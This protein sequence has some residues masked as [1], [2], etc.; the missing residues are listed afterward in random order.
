MPTFCV[1]VTTKCSKPNLI[2]SD[3]D[4]MKEIGQRLQQK[5]LQAKL[6]IKE[7]VDMTG[8]PRSTLQNYEAGIR[9]PP[10]ETVKLL[11]G[12]LKTT[13]SYLFTLVDHEGDD[14]SLPFAEIKSLNNPFNN[15]VAFNT[16]I[17]NTKNIPLANLSTLKVEDDLIEPDVMKGSEV[18]IDTSVTEIEKTDIYAIRDDSGRILCLWGRKEVGKNEF[19]VYATKDTHFPALTFSNENENIQIIGR[20]ICVTTW[21]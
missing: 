13:P 16:S 5:R 3:N 12:V 17:L 15:S 4:T 18:L 6:S 2:E 21:R 1:N 7:L 10:L 8:I 20:V 11:A 9:T 14:S 19:T